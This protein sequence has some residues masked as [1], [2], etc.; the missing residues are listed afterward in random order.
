[1]LQNNF[2]NLRIK[3][4]NLFLKYELMKVISDPVNA[5]MKQTIYKM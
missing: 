1:M 5:A 3:I 2:S 4:Y